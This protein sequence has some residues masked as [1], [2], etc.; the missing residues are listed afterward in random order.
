MEV[1]D[2][3]DQ[4]EQ[5]RKEQEAVYHSAAVRYGLSDSAMWIIYLVSDGG[6]SYTQQALCREC[7]CAKQTINTAIN[8]LVQKECVYLEAIPGTRNEKRVLLTKKGQALV[9]GTT[10]LLKAAEARAYGKL[11]EEERSTYLELTSR[12]TGYLKMELH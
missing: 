8:Q 9:A 2:F 5:Q 6:A 11:T 3:I 1:R 4:I 7:C 10:D 12:I